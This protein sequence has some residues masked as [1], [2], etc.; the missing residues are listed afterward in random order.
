[1]NQNF[2]NQQESV[3]EASATTTEITPK[4]K[5]FYK[6]WWFWAIVAAALVI[7]IA[8]VSG[9]EPDLIDLPENEYRA[10]CREYS[11]DEIA[12]SPEKYETKLAKFTG[13]VVQVLR[14][15]DELQL[16]VNV[17][18]GEYGLYEDTVFVFYTITNDVNVLEG[19]IITMYGELRGMQ[20]YETVLGAEMSIPRIYVKYIDIVK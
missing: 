15:G 13:E 5:K 1:M 6:K 11:Y 10:E 19:D 4:K 17:T 3:N 12:R 14:D 2:Q 8:L 18:E 7:I 20:E 9:G 16:R